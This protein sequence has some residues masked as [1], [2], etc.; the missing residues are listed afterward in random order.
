M[1]NDVWPLQ[2]SVME[3]NRECSGVNMGSL[4]LNSLSYNMP[5]NWY[6]FSENN[7]IIVINAANLSLFAPDMNVTMD[8]V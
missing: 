5:A 3:S 2:L 7:S 8:I 1:V 6:S 4:V